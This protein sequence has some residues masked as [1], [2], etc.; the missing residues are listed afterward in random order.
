MTIHTRVWIGLVSFLGIGLILAGCGSTTSAPL[1][2][3]AGPLSESSVDE[4]PEG[5]ATEMPEHTWS[6]LLS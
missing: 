5:E 2:T 4:T 6:Q 3:Q 1:T